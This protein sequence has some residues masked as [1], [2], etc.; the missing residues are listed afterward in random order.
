MRTRYSEQ[1]DFEQI[2]TLLGMDKM[3][4]LQAKPKADSILPALYVTCSRAEQCLSCNRV[5]VQNSPSSA[6]F[7]LSD[8]DWRYH[9]WKWGVIFTDNV[10]NKQ[11]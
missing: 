3:E 11:L 5:L 8:I 1:Y 9:T 6:C 10:S 4:G 7:S 2:S